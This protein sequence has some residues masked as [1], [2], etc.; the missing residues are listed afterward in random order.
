MVTEP[1]VTLWFRQGKRC[2]WKAIGTVR[3][4]GAALEL[5]ERAGL[6]GGQWWFS[7]TKHPEPAAIAGTKTSQ[8]S[9][10]VG[11]ED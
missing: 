8:P 6:R 10:F 7:T 1:L 3:G 11:G 9:L 2:R 5:G 4:Y